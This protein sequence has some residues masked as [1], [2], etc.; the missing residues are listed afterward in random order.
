MKNNLINRTLTPPDKGGSEGE[1]QDREERFLRWVRAN[2]KPEHIFTD[3]ELGK[4]AEANG[5]SKPLN[6]TY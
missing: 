6:N 1:E 2:Y 4:W 3:Y 5:Y